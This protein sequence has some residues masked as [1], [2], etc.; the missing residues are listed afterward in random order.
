MSSATR[1]EPTIVD[2]AALAGVSTGTVS[3]VLN[4]PHR[5][6]E[7]TKERV[8]VAIERTGFIRNGNARWLAAGSADSVAIVVPDITNSLF[9]DMSRGAQVAAREIGLD[10]LIANS[11]SN[12]AQQ[13]DYLDRFAEARTAGILLAPMV[14]STQGVQRVRDHGR[15]VVLLNYEHPDLDAC[16]VLMDNYQ[17]GRM[18]ATHL[19]ELGYRRLV[20]VGADDSLQP[21]AERRRGIREIARESGV[22]LEEM[23]V[24]DIRLDGEGERMGAAL[25]ARWRP[26]DEPIGVMVVTDTLAQGTLNALL[27]SGGPRVP[28]DIAM[29]GLDG[30]R[31]SW[32]TPI[33]MSTLTLPGFAMG[34][35]ALRLLE[36]EGLPNHVHERV[37]VP[38]ELNA[39]QSTL[40][41]R[42]LTPS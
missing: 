40:G 15:S 17:G 7:L 24:V 16:S 13:D 30:N 4:R 23:D 39:R 12:R 34:G 8:R 41:R 22:S 20:F 42:T 10:L 25:A 32:D 5:V 26:G 6:S 35:E 31:M 37:V 14:D 3:N 19:V 28:E 9:V 33:T 27:A 21:V 38:V 11:D 1:R 18:A 2:V 29:M 36:S